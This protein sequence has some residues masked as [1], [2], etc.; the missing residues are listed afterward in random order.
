MSRGMG[1]AGE[2]DVL[3]ASLV[4]ALSQGFGKT[5]FTEAFCPDWENGALFISHMGEINPDVSAEKLHL[6]EKEFPWTGALNPAILACAPAPGPAVLVNLAPGPDHTFSLI[7]A[8]VEVLEDT[9]NPALK[10]TVRGWIRP[11]TS[12]EGFLESYSRCGGTHHSALILGERAEAIAAFA[13]FLGIERTILD[14]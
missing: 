4:G 7:V 10:K 13:S 3:T 9:T 6:C 1:Y 5:T 2:G 14:E 11:K 8:P 12:L